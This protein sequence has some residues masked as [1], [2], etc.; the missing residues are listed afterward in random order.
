MGLKELKVGNVRDF[1]FLEGY[2]EPTLLVVHEPKRSWAGRALEKLYTC[3]LSAISLDLSQKKS[4]PLVWGASNLPFDCKLAF[5]VPEPVGG[6]LLFS[7]N[8]I[9]YFNQTSKHCLGLNEDAFVSP[10]FPNIERQ[11]GLEQLSLQRVECCVVSVKPQTLSLF[12][13][14][15][16]GQLFH[17][18]LVLEGRNVTS[19]HLS[20]SLSSLPSSSLSL[21]SPSLLFLASKLG[22]SLLVSF[23][24]KKI[25]PSSSLLSSSLPSTSS[26]KLKSSSTNLNSNTGVKVESQL[27]SLFEEGLS[28]VNKEKEK[29][30]E[31]EDLFA[32]PLPPNTTT[33]TQ[34]AI[35]TTTRTTDGTALSLESIF[36]TGEEE[37][38]NKQ[39][40]SFGDN[41][42]SSDNER[43]KKGKLETQFSFSLQDVLL[44]LGPINDLTVADSLDSAS[45]SNSVKI[46]QLVNSSFSFYSLTCFHQKKGVR[47]K[48]AE[49]HCG[50][51]W[52]GED[53]MHFHHSNNCKT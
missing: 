35:T 24:P 26:K 11:E 10:P 33:P 25:L 38:K 14:I 1:V 34:K 44:N 6:V 45:L 29:L 51:Q 21:L 5:P 28:Q 4:H 41:N 2:F 20:P 27:S 19:L 49:R 39:A 53:R 9:F 17:A 22:D 12:L 37:N 31:L 13:S 18:N 3:C 32:S 52:S 23:K 42:S 40:F 46:N 47:N 7:T 36:R 15:Q 30:S 16:T 50:V 43:N 48:E 8:Y